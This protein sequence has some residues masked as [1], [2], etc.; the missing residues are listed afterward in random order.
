MICIFCAK[1]NKLEKEEKSGSMC[2]CM[3]AIRGHY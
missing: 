3:W 1:K 2:V